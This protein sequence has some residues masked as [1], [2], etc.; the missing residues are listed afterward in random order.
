MNL[1]PYDLLM[2][3]AIMSILLFI[4]QYLRAKVTLVQKLLLPSSLIAGFFGL[5][6]GPQFLNVLPFSSET[7]SYA[8]LLVVFLFATLFIGNEGGGSFKKTMNEVGD[9]FLDRKSVV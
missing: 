8:Y 9:T 2:D 7:G 4:A 6:F 5:F 3:F 1:S